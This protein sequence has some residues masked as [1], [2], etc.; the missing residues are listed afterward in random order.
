MTRVMG[1][2]PGSPPLGAPPPPTPSAAEIEYS[3]LT[4]YFE[5]VVKYTYGA[6]AVV[7]V[8][9]AGLLWKS[10]SDLKSEAT[11]TATREARKAISEAL[12]TPKIQGMIQKAVKEK[13]GPAVDAELAKTLEARVRALETHIIELGEISNQGAR[14]RIGLRSAIDALV[15]AT[16][17]SDPLLREYAKSTLR[18]IGADYETSIKQYMKTQPDTA[19]ATAAKTTAPNQPKTP[20]EFMEIIRHSEDVYLVAAAFHDLTKVVGTQIPAF[21]VPAAERWCAEHRPKCD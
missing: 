12:D 3:S 13:V 2:P 16:N 6:I 8:L 5:K 21:D 17:S 20:K 10:M 19:L 7:I 9:A 18:Q 11:D 1:E 4:G 14:L 15:K